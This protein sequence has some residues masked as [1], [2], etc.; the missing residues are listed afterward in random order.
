[1]IQFM[2]YYFSEITERDLRGYEITGFKPGAK[3]VEILSEI[4]GLPLLS[5]KQRALAEAK[6][7]SMFIVE[8]S[9]EDYSIPRYILSQ[10]VQ[11]LRMQFILTEGRL[12]LSF[13]SFYSYSVEDTLARAIHL[14]IDG[15][16]YA[17]RECVMK[18]KIDTLSYDKLFSRAKGDG[19]EISTDIAL[20][21][22]MY[23]LRLYDSAKASYEEFVMENPGEIASYLINLNDKERLSFLFKTYKFSDKIYEDALRNTTAKRRPALTTVIMQNMRK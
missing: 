21:R 5:I 2:D 8:L 23:P 1:M 7:I 15:C 6:E 13:P 20:A 14:K 3:R 16:G 19:L 12:E 10:T 11:A 4:E 22:L 9:N 18:H 17:Y